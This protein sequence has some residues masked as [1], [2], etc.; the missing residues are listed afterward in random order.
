MSVVDSVMLVV[1][2]LFA[3]LWVGSVVFVALAVLPLARDSEIAREAIDTVIDRFVTLS[4][5][6]AFF[7]LVTGAHLIGTRYTGDGLTDLGPLLTTGRGHLVLA[8]F[9]LW[10]GLAAIIEIS[11]SRLRDGLDQGKLR[12]PAHA[13]L[14]WYRAAAIVALV[15]VVI[16]GLLSSGLAF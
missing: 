7:L 3:A 2:Q 15:L 12:E 8:M 10:F 9:G 6:S 11:S 5:A 13:A 16:G 1:H 4:R 14:P